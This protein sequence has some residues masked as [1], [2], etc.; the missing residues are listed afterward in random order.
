M[1]TDAAL[2]GLS[3]LTKENGGRELGRGKVTMTGRNGIE[4]GN[5]GSD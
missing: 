3:R 5:G 2:W 1:H 4:G